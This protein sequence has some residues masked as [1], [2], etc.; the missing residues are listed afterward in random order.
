MGGKERGKV[1]VEIKNK[2]FEF[3]MVCLWCL[4]GIHWRYCVG[5]QMNLI[6]GERWVGNKTLGVVSG[7]MFTG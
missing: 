6:L 4:L 5:R 2:E 7:V 1:V 3:G